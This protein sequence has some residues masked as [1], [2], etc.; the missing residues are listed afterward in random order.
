MA[1]PACTRPAPPPETTG[2]AGVLGASTSTTKTSVGA[3]P[4]RLDVAE[5]P[6]SLG[7]QL[8]AE[9]RGLDAA[10]RQLR[11]GGHVAVDEDHPGVE[12]PHEPRPF[13]LV[14]GPG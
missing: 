9:P 5:L 10:E 6:D 3:D 4:H 7:E 14:I 2:Q 13:G 8:P 12:I 1:C 11:V